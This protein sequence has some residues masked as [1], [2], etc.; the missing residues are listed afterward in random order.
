MG[1]VYISL[2]GRR[3]RRS[4]L[5]FYLGCLVWGIVLAIYITS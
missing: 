2:G 1:G 3:L 5:I 4:W